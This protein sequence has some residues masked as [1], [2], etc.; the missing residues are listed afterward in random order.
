MTKPLFFAIH[1]LGTWPKLVLIRAQEGDVILDILAM[2]VFGLLP[3]GL[4]HG[5]FLWFQAEDVKN[6]KIPARGSRIPGSLQKFL[7]MWDFSFMTWGDLVGLSLVWGA[8][9]YMMAIQASWSRAS[10]YWI[11]AVGIVI[12]LLAGFG[13]HMMCLAPNHK[14]DYGFPH[15]GEAS[16]AGKVYSFFFGLSFT[17]GTMGL[18]FL[19]IQQDLSGFATKMPLAWIWG[20]GFAVWCAAG[21]RDF[22]MG[23]F[24]PF[25]K[26]S[27]PVIIH[28]TR[29]CP[30]CD[31]DRYVDEPPGHRC[32]SC[33]VH[34]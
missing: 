4:F 18:L 24:A 26:L 32:K 22:L 17:I 34:F 5:L 14:P 7:H 33:G 10:A 13:F 19:L 3:V 23:R 28:L 8:S 6:Q 11:M 20:V 15:V 27:Q 2:A 1:R 31:S 30:K 25:E 9:V 16:R 12:G 21:I 29:R